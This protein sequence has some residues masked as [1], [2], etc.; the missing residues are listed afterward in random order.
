MSLWHVLCCVKTR[1]NTPMDLTE[2]MLYSSTFWLIQVMVCATSPC[3]IHISAKSQKASNSLQGV[4]HCL[5][6][7]HLHFQQ[8]TLRIPVHQ[9]PTPHAIS[10]SNGS[11]EGSD[12]R[13]CYRFN[14][15]RA[16]LSCRPEH[17]KCS[18][19]VDRPTLFRIRLVK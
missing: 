10:Y 1:S 8:K 5:L 16:P 19:K 18:S 4:T 11:G 7:E 13:I 9:S 3:C 17:A 2:F 6:G 14:S 12:I 15:R